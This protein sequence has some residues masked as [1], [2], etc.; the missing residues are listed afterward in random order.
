MLSLIEQ[1]DFDR[2]IMNNGISNEAT[3]SVSSI[4]DKKIRNLFI[5]VKKGDTLKVNVVKGFVNRT[6]LAA[7]LKINQNTIDQ[8]TSKEYQI[9]VKN[10]NRLKLSELN[11]ELFDKVY[12]K[13]IVKNIKEF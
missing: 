8:L 1:L 6:D 3:I 10:I 7:M 13:D 12:G 5:N 11:Q 4:S 9:T 2:N